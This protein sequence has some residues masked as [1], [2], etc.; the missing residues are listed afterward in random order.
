MLLQ[1]SK[2]SKRRELHTFSRFRGVMVWSV[3]AGMAMTVGNLVA[4]EV[5]N[6]NQGLRLAH[7]LCAE[8]H[9]VDKLPGQSPNLIA[10]SFEHIANTP[11]MNSAAL[12]AA[13][14]TSHESMP[15]IIIKGSDLSDVIAYILSLNE[16]R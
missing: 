13:L 12:T 5:G 3:L 4:Q 1:Q 16:R 7:T 8:C 6:S 2:L 10:P 15:N 14:R 11:G 9:L